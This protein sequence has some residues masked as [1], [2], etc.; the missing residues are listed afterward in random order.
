MDIQERRRSNLVRWLET[1]SAPQKEK[2]L[3]SQLKNGGSF[4]ERVARRLEVDYG[5]GAGFLDGEH[6]SEPAN[7]GQKTPLSGE[8]KM[9][10]ACIE[11]TDGLG[12]PARK[13]FSHMASILQL[14]LNM[15]SLQNR[16][17]S[18]I[19]Q[20]DLSEAE[21]ILSDTARSARNGAPNNATR[22]RTAK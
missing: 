17:T 12:D 21:D 16:Q 19:T 11:R 8:A 22:K 3:F 15:G 7:R 4:G 10:L 14:A 1:H 5:M 20:E 18:H 13:M 9:L 2:S 6:A